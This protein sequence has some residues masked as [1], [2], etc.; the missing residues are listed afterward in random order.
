MLGIVASAAVAQAPS[1]GTPPP[2]PPAPQGPRLIER[3]TLTPVVVPGA[4]QNLLRE[5]EE[6]ERAAKADAEGGEAADA[7][8]PPAPPADDPK[9]EAVQKPGLQMAPSATAAASTPV[10]PTPVAP[11]PAAAGPAAA[12]LTPLAMTVIRLLCALA[13]LVGPTVAAMWM[14]GHA[15]PP[16]GD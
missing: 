6:A 8:V 3:P 15:P 11:L 13:M 10:A 5:V 14:L 9:P 7:D 2:A 4:K 12:P 16:P 1:G